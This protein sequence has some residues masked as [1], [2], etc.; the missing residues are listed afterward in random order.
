M[1]S[2]THYH[3]QLGLPDKGYALKELVIF[4]KWN[5]STTYFVVITIFSI[6][7]FQYLQAAIG[8]SLSL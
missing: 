1:S 3:V 8:W 2:T 7:N 6:F 5:V 4:N